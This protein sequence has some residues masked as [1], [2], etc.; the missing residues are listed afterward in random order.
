VAVSFSRE[1]L[2][3]G[4]SSIFFLHIIFYFCFKGAGI[5]Y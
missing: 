2:L 1:I 4:T 5:A 3:H